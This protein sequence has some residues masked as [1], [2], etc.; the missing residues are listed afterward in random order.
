MKLGIVFVAVG[1]IS[2]IALVVFLV[3]NL[4]MGDYVNAVWGTIYTGIAGGLFLY[5]GIKRIKRQTTK[6]K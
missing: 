4:I 6:C 1:V 5:S 3:M 2:L